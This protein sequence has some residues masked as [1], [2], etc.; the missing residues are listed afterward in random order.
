[1]HSGR[2]PGGSVVDDVRV[3][4][5]GAGTPA[6]QRHLPGLLQLLGGLAEAR[7][8]QLRQLEFQML[9]LPVQLDDQPLE[10]FGGV[11]QGVQVNHVR[12]FTVYASPVHELYA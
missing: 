4:L 11:G 3:P 1:V 9:D 5:A 2:A 7:A 8:S 6:L 12:Y 10:C